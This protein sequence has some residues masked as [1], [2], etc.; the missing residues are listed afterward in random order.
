MISGDNG[1]DEHAENRIERV[2]KICANSGTSAKRFHRCLHGKHTG[3]QHREAK[4]YGADIFCIW[5]VCRPLKDNTNNRN[6]WRQSSWL[7]QGEEKVCVCAS[8]LPDRPDAESG[9]VTV[10]PI[11]APIMT[12]LQDRSFK[13][14]ALTRPTTITVVAEEL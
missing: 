3:E 2:A 14:P 7:K 4:Q 11:F 8:F 9:A 5:P 1:A 12:Q 13:I 6:D 10:V